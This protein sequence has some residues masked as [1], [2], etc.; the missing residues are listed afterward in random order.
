MIPRGAEVGWKERQY[1]ALKVGGERDLAL[2]ECS[3]ETRTLL[4]RQA[5][6]AHL[7]PRSYTQMGRPGLQTCRLPT[8]FRRHAM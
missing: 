1:G 6:C 7:S 2:A 3:E 4:T 8:R 5:F